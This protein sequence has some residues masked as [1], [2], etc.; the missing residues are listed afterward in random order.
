L[1][2][3]G[4]CPRR[5]WRSPTK[6]CKIMPIGHIVRTSP[7]LCLQTLE[8]KLGEKLFW[9]SWKPG[10]SII[11]KIKMIFMKVNTLGGILT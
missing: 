10:D 9:E 11:H 6:S 2:C 4:T 7:L 1:S 3:P 5:T 8:R